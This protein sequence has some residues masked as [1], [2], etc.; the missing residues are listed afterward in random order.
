[1][2]LKKLF[3]LALAVCMM[4]LAVPAAF[5]AGLTLDYGTTTT[6]PVVEEY[7]PVVEV[8][9]PVVYN[10]RT[11]SRA[12]KVDAAGLITSKEASYDSVSNSATIKIEA[13]TIGDADTETKP[14]PTDI[15]LLLDESKSMGKK[16]YR[17]DPITF[18]KDNSNMDTNATYYVLVNGSYVAVKYCTS[19][20]LFQS[21]GDG[22]YTGTHWGFHWGSYYAPIKE[23]Y[24]ST[25]QRIDEYYNVTRV[26]FYVRNE[27][28]ETKIE[29]LKAEAINFVGKI[30]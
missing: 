13:Y 30:A 1:M 20:H 10:T 15:V 5:A 26:P 29:L 2:K 17:Y 22:W 4:A 25:E 6:T 8:P 27:V 9:T 7:T 12:S 14:V 24:T 16:A 18:K 3:A 28:D 19:F 11:T 23:A 21:I